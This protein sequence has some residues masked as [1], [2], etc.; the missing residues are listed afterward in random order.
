MERVTHHDRD[1]AYRV[2]DRGGDG[3]T[4][5]FIHGS[6][7]RKTSGKAQARVSDRFPVVALDLSGHGDSGDI[8][9]SAGPEGSTRTRTTWS[10]SRRRRERPSSVATR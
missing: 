4:V 8:D 1:T 3:P 7:G 6:G 9:A 5:C 10:P 2:S